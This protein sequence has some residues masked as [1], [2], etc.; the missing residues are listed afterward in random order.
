MATR[1]DS[2]LLEV[3]RALEAVTS[4]TIR[5]RVGIARVE[6]LPDGSA[7]L[8]PLTVEREPAGGG[9]QR[10]HLSLLVVLR[11]KLVADGA[12]Q[13]AWYEVCEQERAALAKLDTH[14]PLQPGG[15]AGIDQLRR[16]RVTFW[17]KPEGVVGAPAGTLF[18]L[19]ADWSQ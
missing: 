5:V 3:R 4:P 12:G 11:S 8:M 2:V 9:K 19:T 15:T 14:A 17:C 7:Q 13:S 6:T 1:E 16:G 10:W 18:T